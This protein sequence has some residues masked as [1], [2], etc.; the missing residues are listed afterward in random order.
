MAYVV[1]KAYDAVGGKEREWVFIDPSGKVR[2]KHYNARTGL[3]RCPRVC[4]SVCLPVCPCVYQS[5]CVSIFIPLLG[6]YAVII[7]ICAPV[8]PSPVNVLC[9]L[10][11]MPCPRFIYA[12]VRTLNIDRLFCMI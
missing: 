3:N 2:S 4:L 10:E 5:V 1:P 9:L 8:H 12:D 7:S 11:F 6:R